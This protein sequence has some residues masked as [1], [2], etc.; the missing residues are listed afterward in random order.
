MASQ[1]NLY[2]MLAS[3]DKEKTI[4]YLLITCRLNKDGSKSLTD[5][6]YKINNDTSI[7]SI[8]ASLEEFKK[9]L[10]EEYN[11]NSIDVENEDDEDDEESD[12][13]NNDFYKPSI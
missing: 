12:D 13:Y 9:V 10:L 11:V 5:L 3:F 7:L 6:H 2:D 1:D 4:D 8:I